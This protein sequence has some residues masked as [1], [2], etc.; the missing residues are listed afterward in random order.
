MSC[1]SSQRPSLDQP[2]AGTAPWLWGQWGQRL[3]ATETCSLDAGPGACPLPRRASEQ[4]AGLSPREGAHLLLPL[5][6][7]CS[8]TMLADPLRFFCIA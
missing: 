4:A 1:P 5:Q 2:P 3:R 6:G 7:S 8:F